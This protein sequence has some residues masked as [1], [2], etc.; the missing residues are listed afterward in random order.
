MTDDSTSSASTAP[1]GGGAISYPPRPPVGVAHHT[2]LH[3]KLSHVTILVTALVTAVVAGGIVALVVLLGN[4]SP[5]PS[6]PAPRVG[7]SAPTAINVQPGSY[8]RAQLAKHRGKPPHHAQTTSSTS[9]SLGNGV[10][11][12][13]VAGW[14]SISNVPQ[15]A[16]LLSPDQGAEFY[17]EEFSAPQATDPVA[18][19]STITIP[20]LSNIQ[21]NQSTLK[22]VSFSGSPAGF[23]KAA[24]IQYSA[25]QSGNQGTQQVYGF[26]GIILNPNNF[27]V[28]VLYEAA[29][30]SEYNKNITAA[31]NMMTSILGP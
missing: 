12:T 24:T 27:E 1:S 2:G 18:Q 7:Y 28:F 20:W 9:F 25:T 8:D 26:L 21:M 4:H 11:L 14:S 16:N 17:A 15:G 13:A 29:S 6:G 22:S 23:T 10:T 19:I 5:A 31:D 30:S 3:G